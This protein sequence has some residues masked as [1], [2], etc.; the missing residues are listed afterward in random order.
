[1]H[2]DVHPGDRAAS[3]RGPMAPLGLLYERGTF[4][5]VHGC[6]RCGVERRNRAD[7]A[8]DLSSLLG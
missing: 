7:G 4:V 3:C 6:L 8:D 2:V 1:M 5:V